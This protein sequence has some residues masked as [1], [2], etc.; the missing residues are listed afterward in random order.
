MLSASWRM[1]GAKEQ[2]KKQ[3][4]VKGQKKNKNFGFGDGSG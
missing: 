1:S 3:K 2:N 4:S